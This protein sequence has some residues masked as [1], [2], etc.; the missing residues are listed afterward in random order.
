MAICVVCLSSIYRFRLP[1][2]YL[3]TLL[4]VREDEIVVNKRKKIYKEATVTIGA[5]DHELTSGH[6]DLIINDDLAGLSD[7]ISEVARE[8][9]LRFYRSSK[10]LGDKGTQFISI[11]TRWHV[12]DV[13]SEIIKQLSPDNKMIR[14]A[15][16]DNGEILFKERFA[17]QDI[18]KLRNDDPIMFEA[19]MQ[20]NPTAYGEQ[21]YSI[22]KLK[23]FEYNTFKGNYYIGYI[24]PAFGKKERGNPCFF[25][26]VIGCIEKDKLYIIEWITNKQS[27]EQNEMLISN[28]C[29]EYRLKRLAIESN[30]AQSEFT[31][32]VKRIL[33][34]NAIILGIEDINHN[35]NKARRIEGMHGTVLNN[36]LFRQDWSEVYNEAMLQLTLYPYHKFLDAPDALEGLTS[37]AFLNEPQ[38]FNFDNETIQG[39]RK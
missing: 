10:Y 39:K 38:E 24:D 33:K 28:K 23:F 5:T 4:N 6:Y 29:E 22:D 12:R 30:A 9:T 19:Q 17:E 27:P 26:F 2:W 11:G 37:M 7:M 20:N 3:H 1:V 16:Q 14:K 13:Y 31:R 8:A 32:N 15:I 34:A 18:E 21:I 35:T 36:V 25:C